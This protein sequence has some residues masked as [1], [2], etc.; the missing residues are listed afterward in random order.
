VE[1]YSCKKPLERFKRAIGILNKHKWILKRIYCKNIP[2]YFGCIPYLAPYH[3]S[4][5]FKRG[6]RGVAK[7]EKGLSLDPFFQLLRE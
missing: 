2:Y 1:V 3:F 5:S 6:R 4:G 7:D